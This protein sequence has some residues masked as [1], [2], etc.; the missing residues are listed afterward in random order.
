MISLENLLKK[1][2]STIAV[3]IECLNISQ[4]EIFGLVGNNG[5]GKTTLMRLMLDLLKPE[6]GQVLSKTTQVYQSEHWKKYTGSFI[7]NNFLIEFLKP[8]EY[9]DFIGFLYGVEAAKLKKRLEGFGTFMNGEVLGI[10]KYIRT[11]SSGNKQKVGVIGAMISKPEV[12]ILDEPFNFLDPSSQISLKQI[13]KRYHEENTKT[14][15]ISSHNLNHISDLCTRIALMEKG[16]IIK[17]CKNTSDTMKE[18]ESYFNSQIT[19]L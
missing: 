2:G 9:F 13:L 17:D 10:N 1:Y 3:D 5:A 12:L 14:I 6:R 15:I 11:L 7:D 16:K 8:E 18:I 19:I 4:G